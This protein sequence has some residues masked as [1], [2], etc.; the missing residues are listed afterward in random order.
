V[1]ARSQDADIVLVGFAFPFAYGDFPCFIKDRVVL[2]ACP[3]WMTL[4]PTWKAAALLRL[5]IKKSLTVVHRIP[6]SPGWCDR[7]NGRR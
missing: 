4:R 7:A 1:N 2:V 5:R 3:S 6:C